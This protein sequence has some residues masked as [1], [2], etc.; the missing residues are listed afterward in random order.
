MLL[1]RYV[2]F[3]RFAV[4]DFSPLM[5]LSFSPLR[6]Y[7]IKY[8]YNKSF[9]CRMFDFRLLLIR[10]LLPAISFFMSPVSLFLFS[11][12]HALR[13]LPLF[14]SFIF[15]LLLPPRCRFDSAFRFSRHADCYAAFRHVFF[16]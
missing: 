11:F 1:L 15:A 2:D 13:F 4:A 9:H 3:R 10:W 5:L 12:F 7:D 14:F 16:S 8:E 6:W